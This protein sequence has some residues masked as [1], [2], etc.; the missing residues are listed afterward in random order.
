[1]ETC[2][3]RE[4]LR[5]GANRLFLSLLVQRYR[6][7]CFGEGWRWNHRRHPLPLAYRLPFLSAISGTRLPAATGQKADGRAVVCFPVCHLPREVADTCPRR[8]V[9]LMCCFFLFFDVVVIVTVYAFFLRA[10]A[11]GPEGGVHDRDVGAGGSGRVGAGAGD[12]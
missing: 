7:L 6:D 11:V 3:K 4:R 8:E 10:R 9:L 5:P 2:E 1:M 12:A